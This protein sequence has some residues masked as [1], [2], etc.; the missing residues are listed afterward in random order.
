MKASVRVDMV[1]Q[2]IS[3]DFDKSFNRF[4]FFI[5]SKRCIG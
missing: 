4:L 2:R 5:L 3:Y 1:A